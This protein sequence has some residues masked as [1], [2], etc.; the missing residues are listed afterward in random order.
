MVCILSIL[1]V[2][3]LL[4]SGGGV[5]AAGMAFRLALLPILQLT[6]RGLF[7]CRLCLRG[8]FCGGFGVGGFGFGGSVLAV[9]S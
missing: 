8:I 4:L 3:R 6:L 7:R 2:L 9:G 5:G 1:G